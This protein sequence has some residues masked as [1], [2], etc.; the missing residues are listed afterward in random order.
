[1]HSQY[2]KV[3]AAAALGV[4]SNDRMN[5]PHSNLQ[6]AKMFEVYYMSPSL[7]LTVADMATTIG[8]R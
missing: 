3:G 4:V 2:D 8:G 7:S 1:M 5:S 6:M